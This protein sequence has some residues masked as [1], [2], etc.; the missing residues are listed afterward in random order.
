MAYDV[1]SQQVVLFIGTLAGLKEDTS[2]SDSGGGGFKCV[3]GDIPT[4]AGE[5]WVYDLDDNQWTRMEPSGGPFG[6]LGSRMVY[7]AVADRMVLFGGWFVGEGP[8]SGASQATWVY[9][10]NSNAWTEMSPEVSPPG[11]MD[12]AMAYDTESDRVLL[13][14]GGGQSPIK[15]GDL[16]AYDLS[17]NIWEEHPSDDAPG[18]LKGAEMVYDAPNDRTLLYFRKEFWA[19]D[20]N[21]NQWTLLSDSPAPLGLLYHALVYD[22]KND[23]ILTFGG[24][25]N[26]AARSN[27]T[28]VYDPKMDEWTDVTQR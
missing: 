20:Y 11:R 28:W 12:H 24:G 19:Y 27:H 25:P 2:T 6:L 13:W 15:V 18:P 23:L 4:P 8:N 7:N 22:T 21:N 26:W 1:E 3:P 14:G 10:L 17:A 16:W 9:D 5:T